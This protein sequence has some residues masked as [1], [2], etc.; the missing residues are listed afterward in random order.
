MQPDPFLQT[1]PMGTSLPKALQALHSTGGFYSGRCSVTPGRGWLAKLALRFAGMPFGGDDIPVRLGVEK[2]GSAW[3]WTRDFDGH[4]TR[5]QL[6]LD[7]DMGCVREQFGQVCVWLKPVVA[8]E[9]LEIQILRLSML[10]V[11]FAKVLLPQSKTVE[12]QDDD[13]RFRFDVAARMPFFGDLIRYK[14]WLT[15]DHALASLN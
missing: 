1:L 7:Q 10:R 15:Y 2:E 11:A 13:G 3:I 5:S 8:N 14:G 6:T 4:I 9:R 12:W